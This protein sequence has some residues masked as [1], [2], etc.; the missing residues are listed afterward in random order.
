VAGAIYSGF[1]MVLVLTIPI[2]KIYH[3]EGLITLR[4]LKHMGEIMLATGLIVAYGYLMEAFIAWYSGNIFERFMM[5]NRMFGPYGG[6][7]GALMLFNVLVPQA[8]WNKRVRTSV[9]ALFLISLSILVGMWLE[10]YVIIVVSLSRDF[11]PSAWG[12]YSGTIWDYLTLAGTIGFFLLG[13]VLFVRLL[14]MSSMFELRAIAPKGA[15]A[16]AP[17]R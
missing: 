1:A 17:D 10:R 9:P 6:Y 12:Q 13:M 5:W 8:L 7:F 15:G 16:E 11:A 4:H 14:P 3:L 2:R